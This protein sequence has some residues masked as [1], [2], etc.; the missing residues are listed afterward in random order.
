MIFV[1]V[2]NIYT[3]ARCLSR[4][5]FHATTIP[6]NVLHLRWRVSSMIS[7][8]YALYILLTF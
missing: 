4:C 7:T 5:E 8:T 1:V 3:L 2:F 6:N